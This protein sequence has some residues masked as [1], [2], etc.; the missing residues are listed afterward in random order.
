MCSLSEAMEQGTGASGLHYL[1]RR[2]SRKSTEGRAVRRGTRSRGFTHLNSSVYRWYF[3]C[4][5][6]FL[7]LEPEA[8]LQ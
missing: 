1:S 7:A 6:N 3:S 8:L 5:E 4:F 2:T